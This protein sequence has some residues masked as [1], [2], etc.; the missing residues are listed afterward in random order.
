[1]RQNLGSDKT[2]LERSYKVFE[3]MDPVTATTVLK[4]VKQILDQF[5]VTFFLQQG[6][7]LGAIREHGFIPWDDDL[8]LGSVIGIHVVTREVIEPVVRALREH[9]FYA[10]VQP[11]DNGI[12]IT[13]MKSF[14]RIDWMCHKVIK[15]YI[16]HHPGV[17]IPARLVTQL[18]AIDFLGDTFLVPNP[19]EEY[20]QAKYGIDWMTP[21][22]YG[23]EKD[24]LDLVPDRPTGMRSAVTSSPNEYRASRVRILDQKGDPVHNAWVRVIGQGQA[25]T[26]ELGYA[27]FNLPQ[28]DAWYALVINFDG[29]EEILYQE[30]MAQGVTYVYRP[31]PSTSSGR[32]MVLSLE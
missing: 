1:M 23:Y 29:H 7:C 10:E 14:I 16:M 8:D 22:R 17:L 9:G 21:K 13:M 27:V 18:K 28:E 11:Y 26:D 20:L 30:Q 5:G 6:T 32:F 12:G 24:I 3:P 19:P 25:R 4:E 31:N 2:S 15:D